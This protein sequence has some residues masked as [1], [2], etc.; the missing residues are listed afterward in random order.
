MEDKKIKKLT[1]Y[2][3]KLINGEL[4][5]EEVFLLPVLIDER[6]YESLKEWQSLNRKSFLL[7]LA[8]IF[9]YIKGKNYKGLREFFEIVKM[10]IQDG[11]SNCE[12]IEKGINIISE[13]WSEQNLRILLEQMQEAENYEDM[14]IMYLKNGRKRLKDVDQSSKVAPEILKNMEETKQKIKKLSSEYVFY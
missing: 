11:E 5:P 8:S 10:L 2:R 13:F 7:T 9:Y 12:E 3:N 14:Y 6:N 4:S 1:E